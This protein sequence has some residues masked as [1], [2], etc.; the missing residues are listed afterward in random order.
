MSTFRHLMSSSSTG[1]KH[2][3]V[4][5]QQVEFMLSL[6]T[7]IVINASQEQVWSALID[8]DQYPEWN[9]FIV[10]IKGEQRL[11]GKLEVRIKL[12]G[13]KTQTFRPNV[14]VWRENEYFSWRGSLPI[15]GLFIGEHYFELEKIDHHTTRLIHGENFKGLLARPIMKRIRE[16]T[17]NGFK[18]MN[19][20]LKERV[21]KG[22]E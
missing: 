13:Q 4:K 8:F 11:N 3:F 10:N 6:K 19:A 5:Y 16:S 2:K 1:I 15:P 21:E 18:A 17:L 7:D 20:D 9:S 14:V 12:D 22:G